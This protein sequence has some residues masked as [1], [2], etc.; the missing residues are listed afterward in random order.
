M[1]TN[2]DREVS[3]LRKFLKSRFFITFVIAVLIVGGFG[4][5]GVFWG[6]EGYLSPVKNAMGVIAV[7]FERLVDSVSDGIASL[8]ARFTGYEQLQQE[9]EQLRRQL[10]EN[11]ALV[12]S[13]RELQEE[14]ERLKELLSLESAN[15]E[16]D[17]VM[18][19]IVGIET[20]NWGKS[21]TL[22][23]GTDDGVAVGNAVIVDAGMVGF[24][25]KAGTTWCEMATVIDTDMSAAAY[26]TR[27][28][29]VGVCEGEFSLMREGLFK[30]S[31]L[32]RTTSVKAGDD[33]ETSGSGGMFPKG[34]YLGKV[35]EVEE[36]G[37]T[38]YALVEPA[39]DLTS[40]DRVFIVRGFTS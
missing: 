10:A 20:G 32:E 27:C 16:L 19:E 36:H 28:G 17:L 18:A 24:I 8:A 31:Y 14:N 1:K 9:N 3:G 39:V 26:V 11:E 4:L 13:V 29:E 30:L 25:T 40:L 12:R 37:I 35:R 22:D 33:V 38:A 5:Y 23:C 6:G 2:G 15:P 21:Y 34:L 7:P